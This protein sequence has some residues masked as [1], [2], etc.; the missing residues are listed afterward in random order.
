VLEGQSL[1]T[2]VAAGMARRGHGMRLVL[3]S[4]STSMVDMAAIMAPFL[5]VRWLVRDRYETNLKAPALEVPSLVIHG[6]LDEVI[7]LDMGQRI[8]KLLP[9]SEFFPIEGGHHADLFAIDK[10]SLLA[11]IAAFARRHSAVREAR[12]LPS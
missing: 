6:T 2:G 5:P 8:A 12:G 4:P 11:K 3:I 9:N 1:G 10:S 7:P